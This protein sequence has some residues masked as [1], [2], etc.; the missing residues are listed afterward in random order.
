MMGFREGSA[1]RPQA[2]TSISGHADFSPL[3][4]S[5]GL[6]SGVPGLWPRA[7]TQLRGDL[8]LLFLGLFLTGGKA[9]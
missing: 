2:P 6:G 1:G 9:M 7:D 5:A 8:A 3:W 4:G